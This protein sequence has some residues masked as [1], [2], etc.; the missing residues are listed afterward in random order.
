M[1][2]GLEGWKALSIRPANTSVLFVPVDYRLACVHFQRAAM[3]SRCLQ[4]GVRKAL[5][6]ASV[7]SLVCT[8]VHVWLLLL[9]NVAYPLETTT[10]VCSGGKRG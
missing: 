9:G 4:G 10:G 6:H 8:A 2:L 1:S 7:L 5:R 3:L